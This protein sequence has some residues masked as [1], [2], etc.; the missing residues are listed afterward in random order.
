M[1]IFKYTIHLNTSLHISAT[2]ISCKL[3]QIISN[4]WVRGYGRM[5]MENEWQFL[6]PAVKGPFRSEFK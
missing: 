2:F 6:T 5:S 1:A 4:S 3:I